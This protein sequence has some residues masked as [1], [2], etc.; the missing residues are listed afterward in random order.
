MED[1]GFSCEYIGYSGGGL[2]ING[3]KVSWK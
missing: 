2:A 3:F 1:M